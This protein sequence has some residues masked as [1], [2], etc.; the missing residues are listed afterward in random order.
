LNP[1]FQPSTA[2]QSLTEHCSSLHLSN[3]L[4]NSSFKGTSQTQTFSQ[5]SMFLSLL[6]LATNPNFRMSLV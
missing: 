2:H 1:I 3:K 5:N 4:G 6:T